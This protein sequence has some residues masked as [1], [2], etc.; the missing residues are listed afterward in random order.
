MSFPQILIDEDDLKIFE[1]LKTRP[2]L[3]NCVLEMIDITEDTMQKL[4]RGDDA[5]EA[6]VETIQKAGNVLLKDWA[7]RKAEKAEQEARL[8]SDNREH[9]KK[10]SDGKRH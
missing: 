6:V 2:D 7:Q 4:D 1:A 8:Q 3:K 5:E 10:K 9:V